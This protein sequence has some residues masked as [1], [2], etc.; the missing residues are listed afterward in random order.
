M[1]NNKY[2]ELEIATTESRKD[3]RLLAAI[4]HAQRDCKLPMQDCLQAA[5]GMLTEVL[6]VDG[7]EVRR[8]V[9]EQRQMDKQQGAPVTGKIM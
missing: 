3:I 5:E 4:I 8:L 7:E 6:I 2:T 1:N 9:E